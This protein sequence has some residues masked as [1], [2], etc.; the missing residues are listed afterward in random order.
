MAWATADELYGNSGEQTEGLRC[1]F[2]YR[3]GYSEAV[4]VRRD[5]T[6]GGVVDDAVEDHDSGRRVMEYVVA[7]GVLVDRR[8]AA[9]LGDRLRLDIGDVAVEG[10]LVE[11]TEQLRDSLSALDRGCH[12][13]DPYQPVVTQALEHLQAAL[14]IA[15]D[16]F[17]L[18]DREV[19]DGT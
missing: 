9:E 3:L 16:V 17:E 4:G 18:A 1:L 10:R 6:V 19:V 7:V 2:P 8:L 5:S 12:S 15:G 14:V 11:R 13:V